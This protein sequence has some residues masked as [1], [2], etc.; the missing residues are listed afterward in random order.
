VRR[1]FLIYLLVLVSCLVSGLAILLACAQVHFFKTVD[2]G[3]LGHLSE[4]DLKK[5]LILAESTEFDRSRSLLE[6]CEPTWATPDIF[7]VDFDLSA[8]YPLMSLPPKASDVALVFDELRAAGITNLHL[9]TQFHREK[10][11]QD[12]NRLVQ[13]V[14][15]EKNS[16]ALEN[17][18]IP[19]EFTRSASY[20]PFPPFL[21]N[22]A[23]P[24]SQISGDVSKLPVVN[25][26]I[27][28]PIDGVNFTPDDEI[29]SCVSFGFAKIES[30]RTP[31][32]KI[33]LMAKWDKHVIFNQLLLSA[34]ALHHVK[35]SD[36]SIVMGEKISLGK[37]KPELS[38]DAFGCTPLSNLDPPSPRL[39][40]AEQ[41]V[42]SEE[43]LEALKHPPKHA[44]ITSTAKGDINI[45]VIPQPYQTIYQFFQVTEYKKVA[46][47]LRLPLWL[48][49]CILLEF[50]LICASFC[51]LSK[52]NC[53]LSYGLLL[54]LIWPLNLLLL[55]KANY[56]IPLSPI[57]FLI[58][59]GWCI[60]TLAGAFTKKSSTSK[61]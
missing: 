49:A 42:Y 41:V 2:E 18:L 50:A 43:T 40:K 25:K 53:W 20:S 56:W 44:L 36:L 24:L 38:I 27:H 35:P 45:Q 51:Y 55:E 7:Q 14:F 10:D 39:I 58:L 15:S 52:S 48:E 23:I 8:E 47:Y 22:S 19:L 5:E 59:V 4:Y 30:E 61:N 34:M 21:L 1:S 32:G 12:L 37:G 9:T 33:F 11:E 60:T 6:E 46:T 57:L 17:V 26:L 13:N 16:P 54:A 31:Y 3:F 28:S 29:P